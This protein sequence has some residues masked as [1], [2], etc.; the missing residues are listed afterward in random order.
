MCPITPRASV[1]RADRSVH[2]V[3]VACGKFYGGQ[4]YLTRERESPCF[5]VLVHRSTTARSAENGTGR[6][7]N[8][9]RFHASLIRTRV[10]PLAVRTARSIITTGSLGAPSPLPP[11]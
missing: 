9:P 3:L 1:A 8:W 7:A 5:S 6:D 10:K 2:V 11:S 4:T